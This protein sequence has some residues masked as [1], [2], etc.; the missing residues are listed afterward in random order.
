MEESK[1]T[2][3]F[4]DFLKEHPEIDPSLIPL[5]KP[6]IQGAENEIF[7]FITSYIFI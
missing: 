1:Y 7:S 5:V 6:V 2:K 4:D 3:S